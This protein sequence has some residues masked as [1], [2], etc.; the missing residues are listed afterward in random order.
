MKKSSKHTC[1]DLRAEYGFFS[2]KGGVRGKY[3]QRYKAGT[4]LA[5]L[6]KDVAKSFP[7]DEA[8]NKALRSVIKVAGMTMPKQILNRTAQRIRD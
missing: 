3:Y 4:N 6:D 1:S 5:L 8:V 2:M 7:T